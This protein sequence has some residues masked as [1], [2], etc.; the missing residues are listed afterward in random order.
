MPVHTV[1]YGKVHRLLASKPRFLLHGE[2]DDSVFLLVVGALGA[3]MVVSVVCIRAGASPSYAVKL[4]ANGPALPSRAA[5]RIKWK[6]EAVTS[7]TRPG[8]VVVEDLPSFLTVPPAYLGRLGVSKA[9]SLD[10]RIDR[11]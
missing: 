11:M 1:N 10:I 3:A 6:M 2:G 9:V 7:S 8:E 5:G 4:W